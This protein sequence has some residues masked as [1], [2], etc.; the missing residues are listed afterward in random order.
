MSAF[1]KADALE[2]AL[3]CDVD[4]P[5]GVGTDRAAGKGCCAIAMLA[6]VERAYVHRHNVPVFQNVIIRNS[7]DHCTID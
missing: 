5:L 7:V 1:R 6:L 2:K 4:K 3:L